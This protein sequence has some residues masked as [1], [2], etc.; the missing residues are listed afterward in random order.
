MNRSWRGFSRNFQEIVTDND[1]KLKE[2]IKLY[3][4]GWPISKNKCLKI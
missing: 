4:R 1:E 3:E 2:V